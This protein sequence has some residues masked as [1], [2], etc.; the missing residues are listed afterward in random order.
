MMVVHVL[1]SSWTVSILGHQ[2]RSLR[3]PC[4]S[5]RTSLHHA[6]SSSSRRSSPSFG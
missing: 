6:C 1:A 5:S 4:A 3:S 2:S